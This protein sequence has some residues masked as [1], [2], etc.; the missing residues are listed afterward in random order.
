MAIAP[1][2]SP[3]PA[4]APAS[5]QASGGSVSQHTLLQ[6]GSRGPE[7]KDLQQR[8]TQAGFQAGNSGVFDDKT[9]SAVQQYQQAKGLQVDGKVGQ[10]TWGSFLGQQLPP[11]TQMLKGG[12]GAPAGGGD[13][14]GRNKD[15]FEPAPGGAKPGATPGA[16]PGAATGPAGAF[17]ANGSNREKLDWAMKTAQGMGLRITST[18]GG[19]H[20]PGSYLY[21]GRAVDVAGSPAQMAKFF[22]TLRG[23][24]PTELFYDPRGGIKNGQ[25]IGAI[26]G[27][28]DHVHV[29][30]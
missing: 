22:D 24:R 9:A 11:G 8:L 28:G 27:H 23:T 15:T 6:S 30:F 29:A 5:A 14:T 18:T 4:A 17:P 19:T 7:V 12:G 26:G 1:L 10:Q 3:R 25:S 13:P 20:T 21:K 2:Q 16:A